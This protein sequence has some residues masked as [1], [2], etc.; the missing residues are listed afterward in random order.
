MYGYVEE[1][2]AWLN[3]LLFECPFGKELENCPDKDL[4]KLPMNECFDSVEN[5]TIKQI[6][7]LLDYHSQCL[8][9]R[10]ER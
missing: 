10:E 5:M 3:G 6:D 1:R 2:R 8:K 4:R 9:E 7:R